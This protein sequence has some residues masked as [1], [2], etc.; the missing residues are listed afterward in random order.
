[1]NLKDEVEKIIPC[2]FCYYLEWEIKEDYE[3]L[4]E[5]VIS[6]LEHE[7]E[8]YKDWKEEGFKNQQ[9]VS[10]VNKTNVRKVNGLLKRYYNQKKK[11]GIK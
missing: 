8:L 2:F 11:E 9:E 6:T 5:F 3:S 7:V 4:E 1:M 10:F